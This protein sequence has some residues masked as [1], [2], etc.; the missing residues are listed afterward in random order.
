MPRIALAPICIAAALVALPAAAQTQLVRPADP[1]GTYV[2][3]L[4][5]DTFSGRDRFY[6]NGFLFA[7]GSPSYNPP[8]WLAQLTDRPSPLFPTGGIARWGL[9]FG[10][11]KFTPENTLE[12]NPD[13]NDRPYAG[14]LYG[15]VTLISYTPREF[16]SLELQLGVVGPAALGE[17]VQNNT[18]DLFNI[19]RAL[20]WDAQIKDEPGLN[21][22]LNRQWRLNH[23]LGEGGLQYGF[24][25]SLAASL[26]N[27]Q[28]YAA[29]GLMLRVGTELEA[30]FGPPR[31]RPVSAG[32]VFYQ[33]NERWG[34]Y[35][36]A[37]VEGRAVARDI[38]LDGNT[39]RDSRSVG[40]ETLVGDA[41][42]GFAVL[43]PR[44]RLTFTYTMRSK[45]FETQREGSQFG[46]LSLAVRF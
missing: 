2:F 6:T 16:G 43:F 12:R 39:W 42:L 17:Q 33:P 24:V 10:Q 18:H 38:T 30:D 19:E 32:S 25:P 7:W 46:S 5:N 11:K 23:P 34:W 37:A 4:E 26:G 20:G 28:T 27:V 15:A 35:G 3:L 21:L 22:V 44:A 41:S 31:A 1:A 8:D 40:R 13:P 36:F 9:A 45:E 14:W 29:A